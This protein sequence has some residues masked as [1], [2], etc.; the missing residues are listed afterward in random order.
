MS[1]T[2]TARVSRKS[3][4]EMAPRQGGDGAQGKGGAINSPWCEY[5]FEEAAKATGSAT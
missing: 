3:R 5:T 4:L 2:F 1:E